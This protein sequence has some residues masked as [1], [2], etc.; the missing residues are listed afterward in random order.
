VAI[1]ILAYQ[2]YS[3]RRI[4]PLFQEEDFENAFDVESIFQEVPDHFQEE[5]QAKA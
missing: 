4:N 1:N 5:L 2:V 3:R